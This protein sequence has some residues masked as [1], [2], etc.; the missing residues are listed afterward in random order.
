[1]EQII[2]DWQGPFRLTEPSPRT[3][4]GLV[5]LYAVEVNSKIVYVGKA[6][7]QG[8]LKE[9][10]SH[11]FYERRLKEVGIEWDKMRA[12]VYIG[13]IS[14]DQNSARI[15]DAE[16]LLIYKIQPSCNRRKR[17]RYGGIVPFEVIN[18]GH[19]PQELPAQIQ[20]Q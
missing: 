5:G 17:K 12:L 10:R 20:Y 9:A 15:D 3:E 7:Y 1:M 2:L 11:N 19:R 18:N 8:T 6:E 14:Q 13:T 16:S 4:H